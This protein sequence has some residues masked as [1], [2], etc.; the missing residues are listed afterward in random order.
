MWN[1]K[2]AKF[3]FELVILIL[4]LHLFGYSNPRQTSTNAFFLNSKWLSFYIDLRY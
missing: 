4:E 2:S 1:K 3:D